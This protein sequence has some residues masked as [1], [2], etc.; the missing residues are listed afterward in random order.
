[1]IFSFLK[2]SSLLINNENI[3]LN[4]LIDYINFLIENQE[5]E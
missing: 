1:M 3:L 2:D 5:L 4:P